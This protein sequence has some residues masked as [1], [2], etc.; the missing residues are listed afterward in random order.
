MVRGEEE[1]G[2]EY[3]NCGAEGGKRGRVLGGAFYLPTRFDGKGFAQPHFML[4]AR[5]SMWRHPRAAAAEGQFL[6][7]LGLS[8][9]VTVGK[10]FG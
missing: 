1:L 4:T 7:R 8:T 3:G 5:C 6:Q 10:E 9:K 2:P